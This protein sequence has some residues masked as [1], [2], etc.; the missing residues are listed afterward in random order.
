MGLWG[1][2]LIQTTTNPNCCAVHSPGGV[3]STG[4]T[5]YEVH[6]ASTL[7]SSSS[8]NSWKLL[9]QNPAS[10]LLKTEAT[11]HGSADVFED[12]TFILRQE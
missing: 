1:D 6:P 5:V 9:P 4:V 8:V 11:E 12:I 3:G 7:S 2:I 10:Y